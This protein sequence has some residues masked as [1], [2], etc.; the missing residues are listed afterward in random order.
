[1]QTE[2]DKIIEKFGLDPDLFPL[3]IRD[4]LRMSLNMNGPVPCDEV[5]L[6]LSMFDLEKVKGCIEF[7]K[8]IAIMAPNK[9]LYAL[10][11]SEG[12]DMIPFTHLCPYY[13]H[14]IWLVLFMVPSTVTMKVSG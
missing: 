2:A 9:E 11:D 1:M 10:R 13:E 14:N 12:E 8:P 4:N 5:G 6:I 3:I 7:Y